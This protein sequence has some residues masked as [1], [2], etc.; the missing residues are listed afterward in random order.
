MKPIKIE[1]ENLKEAIN[2]G[3]TYIQVGNKNFMLLEIED[4]NKND[5]YLVTDPVEESKLLEALNEYNP[6]LSE[7][8]IN[9]KLG[10]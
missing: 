1:Q 7:E 5:G 3:P 10:R 8:D 2:N 9:N 4:I 6:I